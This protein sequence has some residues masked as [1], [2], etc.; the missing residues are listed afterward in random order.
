MRTIEEKKEI[1]HLQEEVGKVKRFNLAIAIVV[2]I[3]V[4][5]LQVQY[6][7]ILSYYQKTVEENEQLLS[8][9][10]YQNFVLRQFLSVIEENQKH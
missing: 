7:K 1:A 10:K 8:E 6:S 3:A 5:S 4:I 9:M 2:T